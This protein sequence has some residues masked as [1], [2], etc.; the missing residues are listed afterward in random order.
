MARNKMPAYNIG[1][2][3]HYRPGEEEHKSRIGVSTKLILFTYP[4]KINKIL[5]S[6]DLRHLTRLLAQTRLAERYVMPFLDEAS[7]DEV[8]VN[9][10]GLGSACGIVIRIQCTV[11]RKGPSEFSASS[12]AEEVTQGIDAAGVTAIVTGASSGIGAETTRVLALRGVH[13]IMADRNMAA[14]RDVKDAIVMQNP[15]A[16]VDVMEL[17]LS[18]LASVRKFAS[19]FTARALPLNILMYNSFFAYIQSK[20]ANV[21]HANELARRLKEDGVE[22]TANS[23]HPG[24]VLTDI[25]REVGFFNAIFGF[26]GKYL[27]KNVQQGAATTCYVALHPQVKGKSG[28]YFSECN[29]AQQGSHAVDTEL[30]RK[31]WDFSLDLIK[32]STDDGVEILG[33]GDPDAGAVGKA[34]VRCRGS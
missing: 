26:V 2:M 18:S 7:R 13:V 11:W 4:W 32:K 25:F 29:I 9:P 30:A 28:L 24:I 6:S 21:L 22:I 20:L 14:G 27:F 17:D 33:K 16:K 31:L 12:T 10:E 34:D 5:T 23:L 19:D 8:I 15:A 3:K 1:L